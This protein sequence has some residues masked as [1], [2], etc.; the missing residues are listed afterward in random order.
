MMISPQSFEARVK[1][2]SYPELILER[3]ELIS[4]MQEYEKKE[5]AGDRS[6]PEWNCR[7]SPEVRY[8]VYFEYLAVIC[9][10]MKKKYHDEY[11]WGASCIIQSEPGKEA[12]S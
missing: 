11:V 3:D 2:K 7:P 12:G 8:Q 4:Y 9:G 6:D 10:I 1:D 5:K